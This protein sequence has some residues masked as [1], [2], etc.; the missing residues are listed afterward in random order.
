MLFVSIHQLVR[1]NNA[2]N[3]FFI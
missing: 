1:R 3:S 2:A